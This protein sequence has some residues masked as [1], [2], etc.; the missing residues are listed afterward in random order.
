MDA[1]NEP[2]PE[3]D[4]KKPDP[5]LTYL[6]KI[7]PILRL[8]AEDLLT[9]Y[10]EAEIKYH[11]IPFAARA[12]HHLEDSMINILDEVYSV[13]TDRCLAECVAERFEDLAYCLSKAQRAFDAK[14]QDLGAAD[15]WVYDAV[16]LVEMWERRMYMTESAVADVVAVRNSLVEQ[17]LL[18]TPD[19]WELPKML[20]FEE[21]LRALVKVQ[22]EL[23]V[24]SSCVLDARLKI[25]GGSTPYKALDEG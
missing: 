8:D 3:P 20:C 9:R 13:T 2:S 1:P 15:R 19:L 4:P 10:Q 7:L 24:I 11:S 23:A 16:N 22:T 18:A 6:T 12:S 5:L 17:G 21:W 25:V 14:V